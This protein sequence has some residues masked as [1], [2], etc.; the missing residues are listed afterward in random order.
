[1]N[2]KSE[3]KV[4]EAS[5]LYD[6]VKPMTVQ[7]YRLNYDFYHDIDEVY[8]DQ[9]KPNLNESGE[10]FVVFNNSPEFEDITGFPFHTSLDLLKAKHYVEK[11][12][13]QKLNWK[14]EL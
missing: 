4:L 11:T 12:I 7:I 6:H 3:I 5:W 9:E 13:I 10:Q 2:H 1:M 8:N 14:T